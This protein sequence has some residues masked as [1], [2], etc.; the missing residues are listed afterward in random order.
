M[1]KTLTAKRVFINPIFKDK[2]MVLKSPDETG[3]MYMLAELEVSPG[4]GNFMHT[5]SAF[6]ETFIAVKG[7][8]GLVLN[9]KKYYLQP[10]ESMTVPLHA[11]HHFFNSSSETVSCHIKFTPGHEG[12]V[13]GIA[14]GYGLAADRKTNS[15]GIPKNL[16][17]LAL[18]IV[19]TDTKPTGLMGLLFPVFKLLAARVKKNGTEQALLEKYYYE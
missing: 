14:I 9:N 8:L 12:F 17:H 4:G 5:H 7:T 10:G 15:R 3:G 19:L 16:Q 2:A 11:P 6:T 1:Q 13:K 18:L